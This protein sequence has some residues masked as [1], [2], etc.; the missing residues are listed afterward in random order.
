MLPK[1]NRLKNTK[2]IEDV[3]RRG[4]GLKEGFLFLKFLGNNLEIS[5]FAFIVSRKTAK[6]SVQRNK[7]KRN[8]RAAIQGKMR[9][10][11]KGLDLV[12]VAQNG[13]ENAGSQETREAVETLLQKSK[14]L[15]T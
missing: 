8:L 13:T 4:K 3:F 2:E 12:L 7:I 11:K 15:I 10:I 9:Q 1:I 5:R 14:L 6:K